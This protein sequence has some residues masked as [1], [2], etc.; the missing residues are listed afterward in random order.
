MHVVVGEASGSGLLEVE[1]LPRKAEQ[2]SFFTALTVPV[3]NGR[4]FVEDHDNNPLSHEGVGSMS[5]GSD[6]IAVLARYIDDAAMS[7]P[8]GD[9]HGDEELRV[10]EELGD[11]S[12]ESVLLSRGGSGMLSSRGL[13]EAFFLLDGPLV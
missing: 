2:V 10:D 6:P 4:L 13:R 9:K 7:D 3:G 11:R 5:S 1:W 8:R 12:D